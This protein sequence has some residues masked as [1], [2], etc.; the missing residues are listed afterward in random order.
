MTN[1]DWA[2]TIVGIATPP[3]IGARSILRIAGPR[4][5]A[6]LQSLVQMSDPPPSPWIRRFVRSGSLPIRAIG[7]S[8]SCIVYAWPDLRSATGQAMGEIHLPFSGPLVPL[9]E[10]EI[11]AGGA[12][13][14]RPG[15][16]TLRTF[17]AGR[18][19]LAEAE[20]V[21]GLIDADNI[22]LLREAIDQRTGG[23]SRPVAEIRSDLLNLLADIEA[24]LDFVDEDIEFVSD[25]QIAY[26]LSAA[27]DQLAS[28]TERL[29]SRSTER[30]LPVVVLLGDPNAGKSSLFNKLIN[31]ERAIVSPQAGT[32]RDRVSAEFSLGQLRIELVDTA[33]YEEARGAIAEQATDQRSTA[34]MHADLALCCLPAGQESRTFDLPDTL[35]HLRLRTK[36][37]LDALTAAMDDNDIPVSIYDVASIERLKDRMRDEL[38]KVVRSTHRTN[39]TSRIRQSLARAMESVQSSLSVL[40][41]CMGHEVLASSIREGLNHLGEVVG[42]VYTDDLLD[43]VFSR[44]CIGK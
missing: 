13:R 17:L 11:I 19:D 44:F 39:S 27:A 7:R 21:L 12:R 9:I 38:L 30:Q 35:A 5:H 4:S 31:D 18:L 8:V 28:L 33:G 14:A 20:G 32:T 37:D 29:A 36:S 42:A 26:R 23:L 2:D 22:D 24:G 43:R 3:G 1:F 25:E 15:E 41:T 34:V 6:I 10:E 16:F 40:E